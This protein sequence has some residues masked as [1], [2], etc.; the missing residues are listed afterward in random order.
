[1]KNHSN[2]HSNRELINFWTNLKVGYDKFVLEKKALG[3]SVDNSGNYQ[4]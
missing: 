1:M 2:H 4:F 3:V